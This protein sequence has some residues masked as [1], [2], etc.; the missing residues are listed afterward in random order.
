MV[1]E[2][3]GESATGAVRGGPPANRLTRRTLAPTTATAARKRGDEDRGMAHADIPAPGPARR[4]SPLSRDDS[5]AG[6]AWHE[7]CRGLGGPAGAPAPPA[8]ACLRWPS[9]AVW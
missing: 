2:R 5:A 6:V 3:S 8:R 7:R 4:T 9:G 1:A